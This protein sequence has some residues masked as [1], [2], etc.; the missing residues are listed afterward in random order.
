MI[1]ST[2]VNDVIGGTGARTLTVIGLNS[3]F[4]EISETVNLDGTNTVFTTQEFL[5]INRLAVGVA[6]ASQMNEG[7]ITIVV[8]GQLQSLVLAN[9]SLSLVSGYTVPAGKTFIAREYTFHAV[10]DGK[11]RIEYFGQA[12]DL[13]TP[14]QPWRTGATL[15]LSHSQYEDDGIAAVIKGPQ[16]FRALV[17]SSKNTYV[18]GHYAGFLVENDFL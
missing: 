13:R 8:D 15:L 12:R 4:R 3:M 1:V 14:D 18:A 11:S 2:S 6:G 5:R 16:D 17:E 10:G 7:E 9:E